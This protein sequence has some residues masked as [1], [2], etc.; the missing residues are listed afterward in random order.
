MV[1]NKL[2]E[3]DVLAQADK[4]SFPTSVV[5]YFQGYLGIPP[6][7]F[8]EPL[9]SQILTG[10]TLPGRKPGD[11]STFEGRPGKE[12]KPY[13]FGAAKTMLKEKWGDDSIRDVDVMSHCMYAAVFD[14]F[15]ERKREF[16]KLDKL[17]TR[18]F[19]AGLKVGEEVVIELETGKNLNVKCLGVGAADMEGI[20]NVTFELNG[21]QRVVRVKDGKVESKTVVRP[22][23]VVGDLKSIGATMMSGVVEI[24]VKTGDV[25]KAGQGLVVLSA[26][27]MESVVS[28]PEAGKVKRIHVSA[29]DNVAQGDLLVELE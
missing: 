21:S 27:K 22:K 9:R 24:K 19:I 1:A 16:G 7:G 11:T 23:A 8:P 3:K 2:S 25:V 26:M 29:G 20:V 12:L 14:E 28:S 5:E 13:D 10:K 6:N 15:M 4:L 17:D 18:T